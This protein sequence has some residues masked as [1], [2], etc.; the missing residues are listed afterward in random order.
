MEQEQWHPGRL[1]EVSGSFWLTC[2][3][4]AGVKLDIF[5]GIGDETL[6]ASELANKLGTDEDGLA[7]LLDALTAMA[8]L[9]KADGLYRNTPTSRACLS[10]DSGQYIGHM[11]MHH[12]HLMDSWSRLDEA[13]NSGR[14]VSERHPVKEEVRRE[15]FLM[16][17]FNTASQMAP[18]LVKAC[19]L[20][21]RRHLL[22]LGGGPGT[23]AIHFCR[24]YPR[25]KATVFDLPTTRPFA[26]KIVTRYKLDDRIDFLP[27]NYIGEKIPGRYDVVWMSHIIHSEGPE[28]VG[29]LIKK[30]ASILDPGGMI[31]VHDFILD[32][33][34]DAPL[35]PALFSL[36][37]LVR[38]ES[39]RSYSESQITAMLINAGFKKIQRGSYR[40]PTGSSVITG[41]I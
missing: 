31:M 36:N 25:L 30:V 23:Y 19:D 8:L 10:K 34:M 37:M 6:T 20:T 9:S 21:G 11:I 27:G 15:H 18:D 28:T 24:Q 4:H 22:D 38:T 40:G 33:T 1:L 17:M 12:H 29:K 14:P 35:F 32:D 13:V 16:G 7:R 5:T 26:E 2:A 39:G 3:L 41:F